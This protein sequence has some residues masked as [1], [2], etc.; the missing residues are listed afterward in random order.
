M[1]TAIAPDDIVATFAEAEGNDRPP[2]LVLEPLARFLERPPDPL[3]ETGQRHRGGTNSA[4]CHDGPQRNDVKRMADSRMCLGGTPR[5]L[6]QQYE[7][8][9]DC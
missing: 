8:A 5:F 3:G 1:S 7:C 2:L 4:S 9:A 6:F